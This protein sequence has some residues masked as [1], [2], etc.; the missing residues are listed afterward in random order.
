M[1]S[2]SLKKVLRLLVRDVFS[3]GSLKNLLSGPS[4]M[5]NH[6][7]AEEVSVSETVKVM[8]KSQED[9]L[10]ALDQLSDDVR[11]IVGDTRNVLF[12]LKMSIFPERPDQADSKPNGFKD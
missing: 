11:V 2:K 12:N 1:Y 6:D 7:S 4:V 9:H 10:T 3:Y 8:A 5:N